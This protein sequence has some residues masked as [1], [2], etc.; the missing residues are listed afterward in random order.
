MSS[1]HR[2][3]VAICALAPLLVGGVV[4]LALHQRGLGARCGAEL[5]PLG[6][7]CCAPG[8]SLAGGR[9]QGTPSRCPEDMTAVAGAVPGC[10]L[11]PGKVQY[12]GG[13]VEFAINDWDAAGIPPRVITAARFELDRGEVDHARWAE[14]AA[15]GACT[16]LPAD[17]PGSPVRG[18]SARDAAAFC[19][20]AGGRLPTSDEFLFASAG[21]A[22]RR[23]AWGSTGLVCRRAAFGLVSGPCARG[24]AAP[25]W[26]GTRRDGAGPEGALDL[27][28][29]VAEWTV[30][31]DGTFVARGGSFRSRTATE[32][33]S[34]SAE[35]VE[36]RADHV[37]FRCAYTPGLVQRR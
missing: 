30:E 9:C 11:M 14:C 23:Y 20:Y 22:A 1:D 10:R 33:K 27:A 19:A 17:E 28:G 8:Q 13:R 25:D 34:W 32:L 29:N 5:V 6:P 18:V 2:L 4:A 16:P 36:V 3:R 35:R 37:G 15:A 7:R 24:G 21:D 12:R 31:R 26:T